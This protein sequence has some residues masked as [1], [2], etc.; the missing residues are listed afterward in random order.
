MAQ[1]KGVLQTSQNSL[2]L[3]SH[4]RNG[5]GNWSATA[6]FKLKYIINWQLSGSKHRQLCENNEFI[7]SY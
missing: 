6:L 4:F 7:Y 2:C 1:S 3:G 5:V